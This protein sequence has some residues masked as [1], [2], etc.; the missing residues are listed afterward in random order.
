MSYL[1]NPWP[2]KTIVLRVSLEKFY[3]WTRA[4]WRRRLGNNGERQGD[5]PGV[6]EWVGEW[7]GGDQSPIT[8][9]PKEICTASGDRTGEGRITDIIT[10]YQWVTTEWKVLPW[11]ERTSLKLR[12]STCEPHIFYKLL[13]HLLMYLVITFH[14]SHL[15]IWILHG[16]HTDYLPTFLSSFLLSFPPSL[17]PSLSL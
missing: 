10:I 9:A 7:E 15:L 3:V 1:R 13:T 5:G 17:S 12:I 11:T 16:Y 2:K 4:V 8:V 6:G 14:R